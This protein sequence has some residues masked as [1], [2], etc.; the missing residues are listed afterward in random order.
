MPIIW[1]QNDDK[2]DVQKYLWHGR[3][4]TPVNPDM[5][6]FLRD[7]RK[8]AIKEREWWMALQK[9]FGQAREKE[10]AKF[11][12]EW[13]NYWLRMQNAITFILPW[14]GEP[15]ANQNIERPINWPAGLVAELDEVTNTL[16][17]RF[18]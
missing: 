15:D 5:N 17:L 14:L 4:M 16:L 18:G 7:W 6:D 10:N 2:E 9:E 8:Q 3:Y 1:T 11:C 12:K 13:A